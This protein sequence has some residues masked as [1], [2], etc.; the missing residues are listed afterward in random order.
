MGSI[1]ENIEGA[2]LDMG[3]NPLE[4]TDDQFMKI[5]FE[6]HGDALDFYYEEKVF[7]SLYAP[8][9]SIVLSKSGNEL[10]VEES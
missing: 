6:R 8:N 3:I 10:G 4:I 1:Q 7:L 5:T 2:L 9:T